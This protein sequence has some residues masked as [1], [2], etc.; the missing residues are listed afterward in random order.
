MLS[1]CRPEG[2]WCEPRFVFICQLV[3]VIKETDANETSGEPKLEP[4]TM[5]FNIV[6][7]KSVEHEYH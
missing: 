2:M 1:L 5:L 3:K 7:L 4:D 6:P